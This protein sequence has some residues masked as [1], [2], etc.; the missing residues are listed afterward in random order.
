MCSVKIAVLKN[1]YNSQGGRCFNC[2]FPFP[3]NPSTETSE[4]EV[5]YCKSCLEN[6][7]TVVGEIYS[8]ACLLHA[9]TE[10]CMRH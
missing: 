2:S 1:V 10:T 4:L 9:N 3:F 8:Q 6:F 5:R 7:S